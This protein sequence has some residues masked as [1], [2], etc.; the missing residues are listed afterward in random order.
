MPSIVIVPVCRPSSIPGLTL[1]LNEPANVPGLF[2]L[3]TFFRNVDGNAVGGSLLD[4]LSDG[5]YQCTDRKR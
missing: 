2:V 4:S 1:P 5:T 3:T